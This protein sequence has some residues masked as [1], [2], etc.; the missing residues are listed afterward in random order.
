M[1]SFIQMSLAGLLFA[2]IKTETESETGVIQ[3]T[4][5]AVNHNQM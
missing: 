4:F 1:A 3:N 2:I 5:I